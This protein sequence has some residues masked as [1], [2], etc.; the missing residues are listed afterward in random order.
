MKDLLVSER[1]SF[2][3]IVFLTATVLAFMHV[4]SG[5]QWVSVTG[6][7]TTFLVTSKTASHYIE[8]KAGSP[9]PAP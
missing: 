9:P 3:L 5:D 7:L 6:I 1:S 8:S 4:V 2:C